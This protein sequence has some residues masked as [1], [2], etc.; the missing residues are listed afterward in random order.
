MK[1]HIKANSRVTT[2]RGI[3]IGMEESGDF[4]YY[5]V[6]KNGEVEYGD[7]EEEV[8]AK[9]DKYLDNKSINVGTNSRDSLR[10]VGIGLDLVIDKE[11]DINEVMNYVRDILDDELNGVSRVAGIEFQDDLTYVYNKEYEDEVFL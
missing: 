1:K 9:I 8:K 5:F 7:L 2:Y 3:P 4:R 6:K 11:T 10:V